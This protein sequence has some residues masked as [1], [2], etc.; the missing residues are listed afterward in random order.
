[1]LPRS[2]QEQASSTSMKAQRSESVKYPHRRKNILTDEWILVS[3]HRTQRPWQ[4]EI[5]SRENEN[6]APYDPECYLC[7]GN[8]RANGETNP[9]YSDT[10][11]FTNDFSALLPDTPS[12]EYSINDL[13]KAK[14]EKGICR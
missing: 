2:V 9:R 13:L 10:F 1:M 6:R 3:P 7:P 5:S 8:K 14:S 11:V 4:G 12:V